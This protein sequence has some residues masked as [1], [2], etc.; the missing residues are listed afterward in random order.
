MNRCRFEWDNTDSRWVC[1]EHGQRMPRLLESEVPIMCAK[2][3]AAVLTERKDWVDP[4][5][6]KR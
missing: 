4:K 3:S 6:D 2:Y 5:E 1:V